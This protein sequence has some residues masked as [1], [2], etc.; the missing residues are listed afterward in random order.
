MGMA[1]EPENNA[2]MQKSAAFR[3]MN[4]KDRI[5]AQ[6]DHQLSVLRMNDST[7]QSPLLDADGFPRADI[8][9]VSV[10]NA[11][12]R[13]IELRND[14]KAVMDQ[15]AHALQGIYVPDPTPPAAPPASAN[16]G[17]SS[18]SPTTD[19]PFALVNG[20]APQSPASEAGLL[21]GDLVFQFGDLRADAFGQPVSLTPLS[22]LVA[23]SENV[24]TF[25]FAGLLRLTI[26]VLHSNHSIFA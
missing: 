6:I 18:S 4:E 16:V 3:L 17:S 8:D 2:E 1:S 11:R 5:E 25:Q 20:V 26:D 23:S 24:G 10:R 13:V 15:I 12:V 19:T 22:Q 9:L 7:M 14:L 21:R